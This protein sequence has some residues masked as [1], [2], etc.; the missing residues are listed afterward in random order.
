MKTLILVPGC[1][2]LYIIS[3][4]TR[5]SENN[6]Q[7]NNIKA[8]TDS[9]IVRELPFKTEAEEFVLTVAFSGG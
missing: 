8:A 7:D 6:T 9:T 3:A 2:T 1:N 5:N 4:R